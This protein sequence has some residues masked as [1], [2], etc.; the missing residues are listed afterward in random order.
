MEDLYEFNNQGIVNT[1]ARSI[2]FVAGDT[3]MST[4][5]LIDKIRI[6]VERLRHGISE[7]MA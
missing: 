3:E 1:W 7:K 4:D 5:E 2:I 6:E